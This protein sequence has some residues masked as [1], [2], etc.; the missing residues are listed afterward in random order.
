MGDI[1]RV[2]H[3]QS[4]YGVGKS[5][6]RIGYDPNRRNRHH[7]PPQDQPED[8]VELSDEAVDPT[9]EPPES[10]QEPDTSAGLD[11]AA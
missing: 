11:F 10:P 6:V 9:P 3:I 4:A 7:D 2:H 1:E 5:P 8:T